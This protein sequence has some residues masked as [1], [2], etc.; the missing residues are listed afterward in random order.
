MNEQVAF[1]NQVRDHVAEILRRKYGTTRQGAN[2]LDRDESLKQRRFWPDMQFHEV[3]QSSGLTGQAMVEISFTPVYEPENTY[4]Y[5]VDVNSAIEAWSMRLGVQ[6]PRNYPARFAAEVI[7]YMVTYIGS[8]KI[9]ECPVDGKGIR[10]I[11]KG[12]DVFTRLPDS[13]SHHH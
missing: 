9:E 3:G 1:E 4:G 2:A 12:D 11:N 6:H 7:W 8:V 5:R 10:W 13:D